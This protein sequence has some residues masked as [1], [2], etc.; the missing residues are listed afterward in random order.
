MRRICLLSMILLMAW[1][2]TGHAFAS[3]EPQYNNQFLLSVFFKAQAL[4]DQ[5]IAEI[6][7]IDME[8]K[9]NEE[10]IQ[11]S[12]QI[13]N[14]ASQRTDVNARKAEA[15][16]KEALIKAQEAK[17]RNEEIKREW[18][19]K[20]IRAD[21][22]YATIQNMLSQS[23]GS[24][25]H[26]KGFITNYTGNAWIVNAEG[27][28]VSLENNFLKPG[29]EVWTGDGTAEIQMLDGRAT[30]KLGPYSKFTIKKDTPEEQIAELLKGK[31]YMAVDKIDEYAKKMKEKLEQ[32]ENNEDLKKVV[33]NLKEDIKGYAELIEAG[34]YCSQQI[35]FL[36]RSHCIQDY[37]NKHGYYEALHLLH[38]QSLRTP[39]AV[40]GIRGTKY[41][42]D[43]KNQ[44]ITEI[45]VLEGSIEVSSLTG[46]K[47][48]IVN[49]GY[50]VIATKNGIGNP[51]KITN[52][53]KWW[54]K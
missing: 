23:G 53:E 8:I 51:E 11:K 5:A 1:L 18:E 19:L 46:D 31:V 13:I 32:L 39:T 27:K 6:K 9:K 29:D 28:Q 25:N 48:V 17:R 21:R 40:L 33:K 14:L 2:F 22:S 15:I 43:V 16:A 7:K 24:D 49:E 35:D 34:I 44:D 37:L 4:R 50:K 20:K 41:T 45:N 3:E 30:A 42:V 52:I 38:K 54:E 26:I 12:Q 36:V 47:K 10:T